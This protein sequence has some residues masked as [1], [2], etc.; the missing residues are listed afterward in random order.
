MAPQVR[1][2][3]PFIGSSLD[4]ADRHSEKHQETRKGSWH[5]FCVRSA[6]CWMARHIALQI[7]ILCVSHSAFAQTVSIEG[8]EVTQAIQVMS[9]SNPSINNSVPMISDKRTIV[10][11]YFSTPASSVTIT[12]GQLTATHTAYPV[13]ILFPV[14]S[15]APPASL[16][17]SSGQNGNLQVKRDNIAKSLNFELPAHLTV[18]GTL[19]LKLQQVVGPS[20]AAITCAGCTGS[21][22]TVTFRSSP[23]LRLRLIG[24]KYE[25]PIGSGTWFE[26]RDEDFALIKSWLNRAYPVATIEQTFPDN[27]VPYSSTYG[28]LFQDNNG[29]GIVDDDTCLYANA[30][31]QAIRNSEVGPLPTFFWSSLMRTHYY[32]LIYDGGPPGQS[33]FITGCSDHPTHGI[34]A[35]QPDPDTTAAGPVGPAGN[36]G[37]PPYS[38]DT[39]GSYG[40]WYA[41]HEL[42]HTFGRLHL[43]ATG[44]TTNATDELDGNN[45]DGKVSPHSPVEPYH[46][47]LDTGDNL[48][49][50]TLPRAAVP[51]SGYDIMTYCNPIKWIGGYTYEGIRER[52]AVENA[53]LQ[54]QYFD[55][56]PDPS[57]DASKASAVRHC[58]ETSTDPAA[59][60]DCLEKPPK[61]S[62]PFG[63]RIRE[64]DFLSILA[65]VNLKKGTG[66]IHQVDRIKHIVAKP[67]TTDKRIKIRVTTLHGKTVAYPVE[68]RHNINTAPDKRTIG[69]INT[70]IP[71][72]NNIAKLELAMAGTPIGELGTTE[73]E[74]LHTI[75][76]TKNPPRVDRIILPRFENQAAFF[77]SPL[78]TTWKARDP[79]SKTLTYTVQFSSDHGRTWQTLGIGLTKPALGIDPGLFKNLS[80]VKIKVIASDGFNKGEKIITLE[81]P[82][83]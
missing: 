10:R 31:I 5:L 18:P 76:V 16:T 7:L 60:A 73:L 56:I 6:Q 75:K 27:I 29:D 25:R 53:P 2:N 26:P 35:D 9:L 50:V 24:L 11:A 40:D 38:W 52:L 1:M 83:K 49:S 30:Q 68:V 42:G 15:S 41:A 70:A 77:K 12:G 19:T 45:V 59:F 20:G 37:P 82:S 28:D 81:I 51:G 61:T 46:V 79:D 23:P 63:V 78:A 48:T 80:S 71:F 62:E 65:I 13:T 72:T 58:L 17:V 22:V 64:G 55:D 36:A 32:G 43:V 8:L 4:Q 3:I 33:N 21:P 74:A 66:K 14:P 57:G 39:D 44:C 34:P 67:Q 69:L 47:G 54:L